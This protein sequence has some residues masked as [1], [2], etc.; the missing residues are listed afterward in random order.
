MPVKYATYKRILDMV[1]KDARER[2]DHD[3][4]S[5]VDLERELQMIQTNVNKAENELK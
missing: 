5:F 2:L 4:L 1:V 3:F